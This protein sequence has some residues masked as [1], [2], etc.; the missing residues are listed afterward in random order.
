MIEHIIFSVPDR[1]PRWTGWRTKRGTKG[2]QWALR[3]Q[4]RLNPYEREMKDA[5]DAAAGFFVSLTSRC[6]DNVRE[7]NRFNNRRDDWD[8]DD[9]GPAFV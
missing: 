6:R 9:R 5:V 8:R 4:K 7:F 2:A 3:Q 1:S